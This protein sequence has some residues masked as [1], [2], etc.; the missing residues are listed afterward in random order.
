MIIQGKSVR[1]VKKY[2]SEFNEG[3]RFYIGIRNLNEYSKELSEHGIVGDLQEG[4]SFIPRPN[5]KITMYNANGKVVVNKSIKEERTIERPYSIVDWHG[6]PHSGTCYHTRMCY[7]RD[8]IS[9]PEVE[10]TYSSGLLLSPLLTNNNDSEDMIRHIINMYL[11]IFGACEVL[12]ENFTNKKIV[13]LKR[14]S[15]DILPP[16]EYPWKSA[17]PYVDS[18]LAS[19]PNKHKDMISR[20]H[21]NITNNIPDFMAIGDQGFY[22]YAIYG[23]ISKNIFIFESNKPDNATYVFKGN[24]QD[25]SRL[26]KSDILNGN[27]C[28]ARIIHNKNWTNEIGKLLG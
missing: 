4:E 19:T 18:I 1:N 7:R 16:G 12:S 14:L 23:F 17:K 6:T 11:E 3:E 8:V 13:N 2:L 5:K 26:T 22:G 10:L 9:P 15:W 25:A 20:R 21:E 28:E 24:W 27:L